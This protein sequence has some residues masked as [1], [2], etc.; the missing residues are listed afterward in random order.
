MN[1]KN[2]VSTVAAF[3]IVAFSSVAIADTNQFPERGALNYTRSCTPVAGTNTT[4]STSTSNAQSGALT[5]DANHYFWCTANTH[6]RFATSA[7][8]STTS[9]V[10]WP[11]NAPFPFNTSKGMVHAAFILASGTGS[12]YIIECQ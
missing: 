4:V 9:D 3:A 10:A 1:M 5:A 7:A 2:L 11:K 8:T 6:F 12:C